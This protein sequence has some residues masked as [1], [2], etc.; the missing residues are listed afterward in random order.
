MLNKALFSSNKADWVTFLKK[1]E[2][3]DGCWRWLGHKDKDGYGTCG[4]KGKSWRAHRASWFLNNGE[5]PKGL[6]VCHRCDNRECVKPEHLFLATNQENTADR[7]QKG[8]QAI[9]DNMERA[10]LNPG[11]VRKMRQLHV[12]GVYT[13]RQLAS[14]YGVCFET[15]REAIKG[16]TWKHVK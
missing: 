10:K 2:I 5:I 7:N 12:H 14:K 16:I 1:V 4:L 3:T 6:C 11:K 13:V 15:A 8:R 9:G